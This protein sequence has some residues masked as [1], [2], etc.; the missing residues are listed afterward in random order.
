MSTKDW[1]EKDYYKILGVSK[2][3]KPEEIKK[4]FRKIARENHPDAKPGDKKAE[5]KFKEASEANS[6]L[7]DPK[8][9]K[10]YDE[11]RSLFGSGF[12]FPGAGGTRPGGFGAPGGPSMEDLFR[13]ATSGNQDIS[14]LF[15]GLFGG[16]TSRR[17]TRNPRRGTD[18]EGE[19][20]IDFTQAVEGTT[21]AM[22]TVS[23]APCSSCRGTGAKAGTV[24]K[25]CTTC[26]GSGMKESQTSGGFAIAEPCPDCRG[27]GLVV[28]DP[29]PDCS[30]SG[31]ARS[32]NTM[33]VRVPAGVTDGQRIRIKGKGGAGENGGPPGDLYVLVN[34]RP[35]PVFGRKGDNLTLVVPVTFPEAALGAD[36]EVPTLNGPRVRLRIPAGTPNGRTF[37]VRGKGVRKANG[38]HG[39]LLVTV[40]VQVPSS[41]SAEAEAALR[42]YADVVGSGNPRAG[43]FE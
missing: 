21:V 3:A 8:K 1:L 43:L 39:D 27:R 24:P 9:R 14:D 26:Q 19:V 40:D 25:V 20:S 30:G 35:H 17:T 13:N 28:D 32:T 33:Q 10:E 5:A 29:C 36:I 12:R 11:Q 38:D 7:S 18:I 41:L 22:Q 2:D 15:G 34:V 23:D 16:T 31:R 4:A 6:V 37:R 42:H